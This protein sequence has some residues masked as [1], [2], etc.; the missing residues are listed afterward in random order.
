M[1]E[2]FGFTNRELNERD[3]KSTRSVTGSQV[4][5]GLCFQV[6]ISWHQLYIYRI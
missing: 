6:G 5:V 3:T 1:E 2:D 4:E